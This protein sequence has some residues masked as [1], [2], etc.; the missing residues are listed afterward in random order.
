MSSGHAYEETLPA[1]GEAPAVVDTDDD[2]SERSDRGKD[3]PLAAVV[4]T[5]AIAAYAAIGYG[6]YLVA[7]AIA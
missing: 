7:H 4:F 2:V 6:I 5:P 3:W 1:Y